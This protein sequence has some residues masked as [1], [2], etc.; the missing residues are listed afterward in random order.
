LQST[1]NFFSRTFE[2]SS[3]VFTIAKQL[4]KNKAFK[5]KFIERFCYCLKTTFDTDRLLA[6]YDS[7]TDDIASE[8]PYHIERW[9]YRWSDSN[10]VLRNLASSPTSLS[11]WKSHVSTVREY[12]ETR[13]EYV[14]K[15][16]KS[17]FG[18]TDAQIKQYMS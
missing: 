18:L 12:I 4:I 3:Q 16:L 9:S 6:I 10:V 15:Q 14:T 8:M 11:A 1:G 13:T 2:G 7:L 5:Q 17:Y